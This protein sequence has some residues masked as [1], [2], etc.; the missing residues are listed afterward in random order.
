MLQSWPKKSP[1]IWPTFEA[2]LVASSSQNRSIWSHWSVPKYW[3]SSTALDNLQF[4]VSD[5]RTIRRKRIRV[6]AR[7]RLRCRIHRI[8]ETG[9]GSR[10]NIVRF[11]FV[12]ES[13]IRTLRSGTDAVKRF[14]LWLLELLP[15]S[16]YRSSNG[17]PMLS[18]Y[19]SPKHYFCT[20]DSA[21]VLVGYNW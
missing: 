20:V 3:V 4:S 10:L 15:H 17:S 19:Y 18:H 11:I 1:N 12:D 2:T 6:E 5:G 21:I 9:T 13:P 8:R 14:W 7:R 16:C